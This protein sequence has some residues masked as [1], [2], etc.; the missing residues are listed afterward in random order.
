[1]GMSENN[2]VDV[3]PFRLGLH[4]LNVMDHADQNLTD[5]KGFF[6]RQRIGPIA[7]IHISS[8][9][10]QWRNLIE[11]VQNSSFTDIAGMDD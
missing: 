7:E 4:S 8:N 11:P 3:I 10:H 1:M 5:L 6:L 2:G 9:G